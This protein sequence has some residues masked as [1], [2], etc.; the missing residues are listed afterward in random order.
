LA[1]EIADVSNLGKNSEIMSREDRRRLFSLGNM[2]W[3]S[4]S[5]FKATPAK[6]SM[7]HARVIPPAGGETEYAATP[8]AGEHLREPMQELVKDL[9]AEHSLIFSRAQLGFEAFTP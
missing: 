2:L 4:D 8:V 6:Y 7:L 5:S 9:V 1:P 3:H